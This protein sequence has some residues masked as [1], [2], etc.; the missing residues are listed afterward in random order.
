MRQLKLPAG[1]ASVDAANC[2][3]RVAHA[4]SSMIFQA[5]ETNVNTCKSMHSAIQD[6]QFFLRTAFGDSSKSVG[7]RLELKTQ[8]YM[9]GNGAAPVG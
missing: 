6:M 8:E 5:F 1:L 4:I 2:N 9:Q 3:D 7:A